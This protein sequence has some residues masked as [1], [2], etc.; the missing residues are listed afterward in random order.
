ML[1]VRCSVFGRSPMGQFYDD[2]QTCCLIIGIDP[3]SGSELTQEFISTFPCISFT[4]YCV[5]VITA[6]P[7]ASALENTLF[8]RPALNRTCFK[9]QIGVL[10]GEHALSFKLVY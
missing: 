7:S 8:L 10:V 3:S 9:L 5:S 4:G 2:I 1:Y 6:I